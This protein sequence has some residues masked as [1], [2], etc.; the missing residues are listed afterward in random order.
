MC[1]IWI[2]RKGEQVTDSVLFDA[3]VRDKGVKKTFIAE[4]LGISNQALLNKISNKSEF[5]AGETIVIRDLLGLTNQQW[6]QIFFAP[7]I[8]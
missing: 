7:N 5:K 8:E 6:E 3:M 2:H 4:K 1:G